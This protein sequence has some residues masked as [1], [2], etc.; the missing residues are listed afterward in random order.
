MEVTSCEDEKRKGE[1]IEDV[2]HIYRRA[3]AYHVSCV[4]HNSGFEM[5]RVSKTW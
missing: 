1:R 4:I 3:G 5:M 2:A